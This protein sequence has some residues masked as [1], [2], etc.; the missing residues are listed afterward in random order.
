MPALVFTVSLNPVSACI[1]ESDWDSRLI[2]RTRYG[3]I[4]E[5]DVA[6]R[7]GEWAA[8]ACDPETFPTNATGEDT[9]CRIWWASPPVAVGVGGTP[10]EALAEL[11]SIVSSCSHP[12][13]MRHAVPVGFVCGYCN[14]IIKTTKK[15]RP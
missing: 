8:F 12:L 2:I 11:E 5:R 3:G 14:R 13:E 7:P 15:S 9:K 10:N 1:M 4:Y 6:G